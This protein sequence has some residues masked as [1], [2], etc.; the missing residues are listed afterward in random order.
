MLTLLFFLLPSS[1][2][3]SQV[4]DFIRCKLQHE[5]PVKAALVRSCVS[6]CTSTASYSQSANIKG[7]LE[8]SIRSLSQLPLDAS[9]ETSFSWTQASLSMSSLV[10]SLSI[11]SKKVTSSIKSAINDSMNQLTNRNNSKSLAT[12]PASFG[13]RF[14]WKNL[15]IYQGDLELFSSL[16]AHT[17]STS[18]FNRKYSSI[19]TESLESCL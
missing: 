7:Y 12:L 15:G 5:L 1:I 3:Y 6:S 9:C 8:E 2:I 17:S 16:P 13:G 19:H 18:T 11:S 4:T 14:C 10:N